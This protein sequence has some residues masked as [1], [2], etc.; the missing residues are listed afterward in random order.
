MFAFMFL[1]Y[2]LFQMACLL[3]KVLQMPLDLNKETI[4]IAALEKM[5]IIG[6]KIVNG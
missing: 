6:G 3:L 2:V 4:F 5:H 1:I